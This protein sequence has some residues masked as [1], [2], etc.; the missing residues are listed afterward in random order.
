MLLGVGGAGVGVGFGDG[1]GL[2]T[3]VGGMGVGNGDGLGNDGGGFLI[4]KAERTS[5]ALHWVASI[6]RIMMQN[7]LNDP[8]LNCTI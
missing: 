8:I 2:G 1:D 4:A 6:P 5:A 3:G 7:S